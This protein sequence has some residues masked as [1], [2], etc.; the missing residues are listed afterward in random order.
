MAL[1]IGPSKIGVVTRRGTSGREVGKARDR[2]AQV[3][4]TGVGVDLEGKAGS[5]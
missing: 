5:L 2:F 3:E 4:L 1:S